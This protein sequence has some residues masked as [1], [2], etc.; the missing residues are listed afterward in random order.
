MNNKLLLY[1][2]I[3]S[4]KQVEEEI[5]KTYIKTNLVKNV[6]KSFK[7]SVSTQR[8]FFLKLKNNFTNI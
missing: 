7:Y 8:L 6:I 4:L 1:N 3:Y 2:L 5:L